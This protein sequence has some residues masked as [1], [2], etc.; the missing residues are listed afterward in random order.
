MNS[1]EKEDREAR[2]CF[3]VLVVRL[4]WKLAEKQSRLPQDPQGEGFEDN[5]TWKV[6]HIRDSG[7]E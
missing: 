3:K 1:K 5:V 2:C 7:L 6:K 4:A